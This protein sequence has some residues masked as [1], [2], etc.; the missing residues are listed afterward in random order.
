MIIV[1]MSLSHYLLDYVS[2]HWRPPKKWY[3][4]YYYYI[5]FMIHIN[6]IP[7]DNRSENHEYSATVCFKLVPLLLFYDYYYY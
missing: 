6:L 1:V 2:P 5:L 4:E 3:G 7:S